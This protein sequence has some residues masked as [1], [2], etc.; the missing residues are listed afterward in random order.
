MRFI[1]ADGTTVDT[2]SAES[3][4]AFSQS[5]ASLL[6]ELRQLRE[7][8]LSDDKGFVRAIRCIK[9]ELGEPDAS[10]RRRPIE[11]AGSEFEMD[12]DTVIKAMGAGKAAAKAI[13]Q[14]IQNKAKG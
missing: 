7:E 4:Q 5:H 3:R 8:I 10:G 11:V 14:Y 9:M 2:A 6:S 13:D 1:L 12:V